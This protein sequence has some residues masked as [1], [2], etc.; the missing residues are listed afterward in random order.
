M[1]LRKIDSLYE[2]MFREVSKRFMSKGYSQEYINENLCLFKTKVG[3]YYPTEKGKGIAFYGRATNGWD[4]YDESAKNKIETILWKQTRRPFL[5][6]IY[7]VSWTY[8]DNDYCNN[9]VWSN[10]YKIAP[11]GGNPPAD[12]KLEQHDY[13]VEIIR[14]EIEILSPALVVLITGN[15]VGKQWSTPFWEAFP[16]LKLVDSRRWG[17]NK[18]YM[19]SLYSDGPL[20]VILTDRPEARPIEEHANAITD[21]I[22][23]HKLDKGLFLQKN[24]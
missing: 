9:V 14:K 7:R 24:E 18:E 16:N 11:D 6:L 10:I 19:A 1:D 23:S 2:T 12:L 21:L 4:E 3:K 8:Y 17:R 22:E 20:N 15:S 5:N 13:I